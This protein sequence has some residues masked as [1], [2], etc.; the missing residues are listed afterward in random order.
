MATRQQK[1][2]PKIHPVHDDIQPSPTDAQPSEPT[3]PP[4]SGVGERGTEQGVPFYTD[5]AGRRFVASPHRDAGKPW[6]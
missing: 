4:A 5:G 2:P 1:V 3:T 6:A